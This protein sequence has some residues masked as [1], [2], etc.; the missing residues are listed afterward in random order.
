[1]FS[2][3]VDP[4]KVWLCTRGNC[5]ASEKLLES[6]GEEAYETGMYSDNNCRDLV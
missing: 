6:E 2:F 1:M 4:R 3:P 5:L